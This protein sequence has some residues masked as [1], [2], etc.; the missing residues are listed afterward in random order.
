MRDILNVTAQD[1]IF[2]QKSPPKLFLSPKFY[3]KI[4]ERIIV[5]KNIGITSALLKK[6][7][8]DMYAY[9]PP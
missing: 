7:L 6:N 4:G 1:S 5:G 8:I 3:M 2:F 9:N